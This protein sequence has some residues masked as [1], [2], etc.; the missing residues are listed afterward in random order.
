MKIF[1]TK[2]E[3]TFKNI[4]RKI[5]ILLFWIL[6][7]QG[8]YIFVNKEI[9]V[10]SPI[11]VMKNLFYLITQYEFWKISLISTLRMG[12]GFLS[13]V[14]IGTIIS[15][16]TYR[17]SILKE[18]LSPILNII[19][20]TPIVSFIILV[21]I[22]IPSGIVPT[23]ISSIMVIPV[24]WV[25]ISKG[26]ENIDK[27]ILEMAKV[28]NISKWKKLTKIVG[29]SI[30]PY[31][32][33]ACNVGVGFAW[34]SGI[35]AEVIGNTK[36]SIGSQIYAS[37]IYFETSFLFSWTIVVILISIG[38]EFLIKKFINKIILRYGF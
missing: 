21:L 6:V 11:T 7:W 32:I 33:V 35:A 36:F 37:K 19:K 14:I 5:V 24:V 22:W 4:I 28:F 3:V 16:L 31:F 23:F 9:L 26:I 25:N 2:D 38:L 13:A 15:L 29:P 30:M 1:T 27:E 20:A 8:I 12:L 17:Y 18:I 10:S 34:K